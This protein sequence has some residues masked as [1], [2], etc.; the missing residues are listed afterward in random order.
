MTLWSE[1]D[2]CILYSE[3]EQLQVL[4]GFWGMA[5]RTGSWNWSGIS[6]DERKVNVLRG[7]DVRLL[8]RQLYHV[9]GVGRTWDG[10]ESVSRFFN[11]WKRYVWEISSWQWRRVGRGMDE[12]YETQKSR[13]SYARIEK[14]WFQNLTGKW[15]GRPTPSP[16]WVVRVWENVQL[17]YWPSSNTVLL[18]LSEV[19]D[20]KLFFK[21]PICNGLMLLWNK[22]SPIYW[23]ATDL[24]G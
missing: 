4:I 11:E 2:V 18:R 8:Y 24:Q 17:L 21:F 14:R 7:W 23:S 3:V 16:A 15:G 10:E 20:Q 12:W 13:R 22:M 5:M 9:R 6:E 1:S 19:K